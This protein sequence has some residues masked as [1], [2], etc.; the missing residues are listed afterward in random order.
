MSSPRISRSNSPA[1]RESRGRT[2]SP[3]RRP[4]LDRRDSSPMARLATFGLLATSGIG[5]ALGAPVQSRDA[6]PAPQPHRQL[7]RIE[8]DMAEAMDLIRRN[9]DAAAS[10]D[11]SKLDYSGVD[12]SHVDWNKINYDRGDVRADSPS[13]YST[14]KPM[15]SPTLSSLGRAYEHTFGEPSP[16]ATPP[17]PAKSVMRG[18]SPTLPPMMTAT[19]VPTAAA[20]V[21]PSPAPLLKVDA[22]ALQAP[23]TAPTPAINF[24]DGIADSQN[25]VAVAWHGNAEMTFSFFANA[26]PYQPNLSEAY[27]SV[28]LKPGASETV[29]LPAGWSGRVQK[30]TG[31]IDSDATW[32]EFTF[33]GWQDLTWFDDSYIR[34]YNGPVEMYLS[35][36]PELRAGNKEDMLKIYPTSEQKNQPRGSAIPATEGYDGTIRFDIIDFW[37]AHNKVYPAT[38]KQA[39][40]LEAYIVNNDDKATMTGKDKHLVIEW[41]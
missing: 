21:K 31:A 32:A 5:Q 27:K 38:A 41:Y 19:P 8:Q 35:E 14:P 30:M 1:P 3:K 39:E 23:F 2:D 18:F 7:S 36:T 25:A 22:P 16:L 4:G 29:Q 12:Y 40:R 26:G 6:S 28:T 34:G 24:F 37:R 33:G 10:V 20:V 15:P 11:F 9:D 13:V 17:I